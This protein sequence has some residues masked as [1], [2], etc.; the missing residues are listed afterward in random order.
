MELKFDITEF[1][2]NLKP[3]AK[4][5]FTTYVVISP[6]WFLSLELFSTSFIYKQPLYIHCVAL[7]L[8]TACWV[9]A[10]LI[11]GWLMDQFTG[12]E[13]NLKNS[14]DAVYT[15]S[16]VLL[17]GSFPIF[18]FNE[19]SFKYY[20]FWNFGF[21]GFCIAAV[22]GLIL[23]VKIIDNF[24]IFFNDIKASLKSWKDRKKPVRN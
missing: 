14:Y 15:A 13:S 18:Y 4:M 12:Y 17:G 5:V 9:V 23:T 20:L 24:P 1:Y 22:L 19:I 11:Y 2:K 7:F 6:F 8:V 21:M 10:S 16:I 3:S